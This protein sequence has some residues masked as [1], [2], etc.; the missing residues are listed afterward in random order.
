MFS[1]EFRPPGSIGLQNAWQSKIRVLLVDDHTMLR[2]GLKSIVNSC[3]H[4]EVVGDASNGLEAIGAVSLLRPDVVVMDINMPTMNGIEA[5]KRIKK[6]FPDTSIIGLS[7]QNS[8]DIVQ[9]MQAAGVCSYLTKE[10]AVE[11]LCHAIEDAA[12]QK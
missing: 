9:K 8:M 1:D 11:S 4:M 7:V 5:T 6:M 12:S 10:S 3:N 2:Q